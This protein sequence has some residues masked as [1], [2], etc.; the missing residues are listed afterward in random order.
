MSINQKIGLGENQKID[1]FRNII[2][3]KLTFY[4]NIIKKT[5]I[6][7]QKYK[8]M[9]I[10]T[11]NELNI[12]TQSLESL[13]LECDD[14]KNIEDNDKTIKALQSVND[15]IYD[16]LKQY[17]TDNITDLLTICYG[18][19]YIN[20]IKNNEKFHIINKYIHPTG[21]KVLSLP[22]SKKKKQP[23]VKNKIVEDFMIAENAENLECFDLG[24]TTKN[25]QLKV[26]GIKITLRNEKEKKNNHIKWI[27]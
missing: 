16:L 10:I 1:K 11:A 7:I 19:E 5:I 12:C 14:I 20:N 18:L 24:R 27:M 6:S 2:N 9:D 17:G 23:I 21:F 8:C 15:S 22:D 25:F 3:D 4:E 26:Y 13:I